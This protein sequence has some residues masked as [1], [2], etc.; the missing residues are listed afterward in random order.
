MEL[1]QFNQR[2]LHQRDQTK[3]KYS[4]LDSMQMNKKDSSMLWL[5]CLMMTLSIRKDLEVYCQ[6]T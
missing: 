4:K 3:I 2:L 6:S 5:R 1:T